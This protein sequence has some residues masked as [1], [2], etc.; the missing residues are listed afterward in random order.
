[1]IL[2]IVAL[3]T[4]IMALLLLTVIRV[5]L[6]DNWQRTVPDNAPNRF[7]INIQPD[8]KQGVVEMLEKANLDLPGIFPMARGRLVPEKSD[9]EW[10]GWN[11]GG[12]KESAEMPSEFNLSFSDHLPLNNELIAGRWWTDDVSRGEWSLEEL[13]LIHISEPK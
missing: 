7:V 10:R 1:M 4:G 13:S 9:V 2:Q 11:A 6:L 12:P 3:G 8:Q 5:D